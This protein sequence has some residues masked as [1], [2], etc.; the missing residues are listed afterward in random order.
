M[1]NTEAE[2]LGLREADQVLSVNGYNFED[3]EHGQ[4]VTILKSNTEIIMQ[5]RY[6]PYGYMKTYEVHGSSNGP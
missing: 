4:A 2:R 6:F 1:P 3:I 5:I